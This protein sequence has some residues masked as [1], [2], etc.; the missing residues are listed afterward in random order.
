L[1]KGLIRIEAGQAWPMYEHYV[2]PK[3]GQPISDIWAYQPYTEGTVFGTEEGIDADVRWPQRNELLGFQTQKPEGLLR[4]IITASSNEGDVVLDAFCGCGTTVAVAQ[5]L[6]RQ[7][8]GI[9]ITYQ[10]IAVILRRFEQL[11]PD[12]FSKILANVVLD[13]IPK[14]V[15][16][17]IAL[18]NKKDD[19]VRKEYEKWAVLTYTNNRAVINEKKGADK[20]IDGIAYFVSSNTKDT[21]KVALQAK[22]GGVDRS[23]IATLNSDRQREGAEIG[24]FITLEKP[25]KP[26]LQEA[27]SAGVYQSELMAKPVNRIQIVTV[28]EIIEDNARLGLPMSLEVLQSA[29]AAAADTQMSLIDE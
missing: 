18:A 2:T 6:K 1:D 3:D 10:S 20:G 28:K 29:K 16:S 13:G 12:T 25:T 19:R 5:Q 11:Y 26:M 22:S 23:D 24:I 9:D 21:S 27:S 15:E 8:I 7:W 17:A 14:D 4:R